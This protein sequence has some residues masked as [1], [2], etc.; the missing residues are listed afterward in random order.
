LRGVLFESP[1]YFHGGAVEVEEVGTVWKWSWSENRNLMVRM[2]LKLTSYGDLPAYVDRVRVAIGAENLGT[3]KVGRW[4]KAAPD[5]LKAG[6]TWYLEVEGLR[7]PPLEPMAYVLSI[8]A[9]DSK[10]NWVGGTFRFPEHYTLDL[11]GVPVG[12]VLEYEEYER[13]SGKIEWQSVPGAPPRWYL[14][15]WV[16]L[17]KVKSKLWAWTEMGVVRF[18]GD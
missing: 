9:F 5:W 4:F 15:D 6:E 3:F 11:L 1:L 16:I 8:N 12:P 14:Y 18:G 7:T 13:W 10:G 2:R 17:S